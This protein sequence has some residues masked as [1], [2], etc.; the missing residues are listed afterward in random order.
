MPRVRRGTIELRCHEASCPMA[1]RQRPIPAIGC[2]RPVPGAF[3]TQPVDCAQRGICAT[4]RCHSDVTVP[5]VRG[6]I[7]TGT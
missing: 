2:V 4:L 3:S 1:P 7:R 6:A 5:R